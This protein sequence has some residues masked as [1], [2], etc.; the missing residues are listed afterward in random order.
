MKL[1]ADWRELLVF[2]VL[3]LPFVIGMWLYGCVVF[4]ACQ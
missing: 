3:V 4:H 1:P 2:T